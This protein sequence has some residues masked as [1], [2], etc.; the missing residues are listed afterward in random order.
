M[1][2]VIKT[3]SPPKSRLAVRVGVTGHRPSGLDKAETGALLT[4]IKAVLGHIRGVAEEVK[5][6]F[7]SLYSDGGQPLLRV[8]SP[9]AEGADM[10]VA[11]E[12]LAEG[13]ELQCALPFARKEYEKD[14][15]DA[16]SVERFRTLLGKAAS[17]LELDGSRATPDLENEAYQTAGRMVLAQ[18]DVLIA[19]WDG[20]D[21]KG[22]GGTGQIVRESLINEI[23]V[24]WISSLSPHEIHVLMGGEYEGYKEASLRELEFRLKRVL[25]PQYPMKPDLSRTYFEERQPTWT[26]GFV[27][28]IF[29]NL[30]SGV[31]YKT[32]GSKVS[33][34]YEETEEE[35]KKIWDACP[36]FPQ[37]VKD[38]INEKF[39]VHYAWADKLAN[40][41]SNIYRS[42]FTVNYL[43]AG[44]A[45]LFALLIPTVKKLET[46]WV[47]CELTLI[48]LIILITAVGNLKHWHE[49]WIDYR[50]LS[51]QL[52]HLRFLTPLGLTMPSFR[53]P[54][55]DTY[56][57]P[58][59]TWV[60]WHFRAI[61][62]EAGMVGTTIDEHYLAAYRDFLSKQEITGQIDYHKRNAPRLHRINHTLHIIG[63]GLFAMTFVTTFIHLFY[64]SDWLII[65]SAFFPA[66]G[67]AIYGIRTQG[68]FEQLAKRSD[69]MSAHL[70]NLRSELDR[71]DFTSSY[72]LLG[73]I[74]ENTAEVMSTE[75]LDWRIVFQ[76]KRLVLPG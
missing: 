52:R 9:L 49:R 22:K 72:G 11:E 56:G 61:V 17:V 47:L 4:Q 6:S 27:F 8:I 73:S 24:I 39:L 16:D 54:A 26:W 35:W 7:E 37:S 20:E 29:C 43:M 28:E 21:E 25:K 69:A 62:R 5:S 50:L 74:A 44:F 66:L 32:G 2:A 68:E 10:I 15:T 41:Y 65:C 59:S 63:M 60:N 71:P 3:D 70:E 40:Y 51:E 48:V 76:S 46:L 36:G 12:G 57:D 42:S 67:A 58:R 1:S 33:D 45:V 34:F 53:V 38:Q 30:F 19:I 31:K 23:P 18:S 55:H 64:H 13:Y 14:F 75:T